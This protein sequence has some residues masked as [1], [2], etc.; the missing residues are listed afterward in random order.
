VNAGALARV[1]VYLASIVLLPW[2]VE[3]DWTDAGTAETITA[4]LAAAAV[5]ALAA[6]NINR[7]PKG[8]EYVGRHRAE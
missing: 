6:A 4:A 1:L 8:G 2:A 7:R 3:H 5:P